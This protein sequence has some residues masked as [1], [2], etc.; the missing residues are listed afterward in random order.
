M[1]PPSPFDGLFPT[2]PVVSRLANGLTLIVVRW[3]SPG[4][5][6]YYTLVRTGSR[7]EVE[8]GHSGFA[9]FFEHMMFR[10]TRAHPADD[11]ANALQAVG[12]DNNAY[13]S[14]DY[15]CYTITGPSSALSTFIELEADRFRHLTYTEDVFRTEAGAVRGE[16]QVWS[17]NPEQPMW[18]ALSEIAFTRHTY[19]HTTIGYLRDID[20]MPTRFTYAQ[21]FFR[22]YYTPDNST[23]IVVGDV[24]PASVARDV[25]AQYGTWRDR[26]DRPTVP[27]EPAPTGGR[28]DLTWPSATP[29][30][31]FIGYRTPAFT[32]DTRDARARTE[33]LRTS[34]ALAMV[35]GLVFDESS[36]LYDRL[37]VNDRSALELSSSAGDLSKDP[38]LFVVTATLADRA[39]FEPVIDAVSSELASVGRGEFTGERFTAVQRHLL[40]ALPMSLETPSSVANFLA[41][42]LAVAPDLDAVRAY[43]TALA[44]M[45]PADVARAASTYLVPDHR[46]VVTL[47][48]AAAAEVAQ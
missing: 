14:N 4:I 21:Q 44:T 41:S 6:A 10:G 27:T 40:Y 34:A 2:P 23:V 45:T 24:D 47:Q 38:G 22:R 43:Y 26:R 16:Y 42:H 19:G 13:T 15:T 12:A 36:P 11:Y 28:R 33:A 25:T 1:A 30:R 46:Y 3:P 35:H 32:I 9:H 20:Q 5:V 7:D 8:P 18:E 17:S 31:L 29:P 37:V 39:A 48:H